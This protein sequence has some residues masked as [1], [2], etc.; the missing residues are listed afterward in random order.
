M[1]TCRT[2]TTYPRL[3]LTAHIQL[4]G[5][6]VAIVVAGLVLNS[7]PSSRSQKVVADDLSSWEKAV[8]HVGCLATRP[9]LLSEVVNAW[10]GTRSL[11]KLA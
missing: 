4:C 3:A 7:S 10:W 5:Q 2:I 9:M 11:L 1:A 6:G 8:I